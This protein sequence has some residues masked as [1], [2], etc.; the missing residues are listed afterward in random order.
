MKITINEIKK[1]INLRQ[2]PP[3]TL[4]AEIIDVYENEFK[5]LVLANFKNSSLLYQ[6]SQKIAEEP[7]YFKKTFW[8]AK[9]LT[10]L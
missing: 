4:M 2:L 8:L 7:S 1:I 9:L 5:E 3:K 6:I 10:K